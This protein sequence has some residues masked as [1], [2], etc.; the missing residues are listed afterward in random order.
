M[1]KII[2]L[3]F[4]KIDKRVINYVKEKRRQDQISAGDA[5]TLLMVLEGV[6]LP[7]I[8]EI[9]IE[10]K[11]QVDYGKVYSTFIRQGNDLL[12]VFRK[13]DMGSN[14]YKIMYGE[15]METNIIKT[16]LAKILVNFA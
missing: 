11:E 2:Y 1:A 14:N 5:V 12:S 3:D 16:E 7:T 6:S 9:I 10:P 13:L 15:N 8:P 4:R